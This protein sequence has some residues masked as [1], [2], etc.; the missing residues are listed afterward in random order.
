MKDKYI[1]VVTMC[2]KKEVVDIICNSLLEKKLV[3][4]CQVYEAYS[5]YWWNNEIEES[6]EYRI[7]FRTKESK[8]KRIEEEIKKLHDYITCEITAY[9]LINGSKEI[10]KWIDENVIGERI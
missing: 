3:A 6:K 8:F 10:Y 7:E 1:V 5:K 2:N 9:E 4:G